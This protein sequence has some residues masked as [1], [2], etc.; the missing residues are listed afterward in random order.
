MSR[1]R[2]LHNVRLR[3]RK[4]YLQRIKK[5]N[6]RGAGH[7]TYPNSANWA[8]WQ[9]TEDK[10]QRP[11]RLGKY[12]KVKPFEGR[13]KKPPRTFR[14]HPNCTI[15]ATHAPHEVEGRQDIDL[16]LG[17]D[18]TSTVPPPLSSEMQAVVDRLRE[19]M[20]LRK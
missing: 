3:Q 15:E 13:K 8:E 20:R 18:T 16:C 11:W 2:K 5:L 14:H 6:R 1:R 17:I 19:D 9:K 10:S 4:R 7:F 12:R